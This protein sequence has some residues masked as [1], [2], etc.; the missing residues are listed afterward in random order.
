MDKNFGLAE[1]FW[2][3]VLLPLILLGLLATAILEVAKDM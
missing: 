1:L 3:I 2:T